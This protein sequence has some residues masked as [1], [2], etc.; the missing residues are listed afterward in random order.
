[1]GSVSSTA[2]IASAASV[3]V[4]SQ[5]AVGRGGRAAGRQPWQP[6]ERETVMRAAR[7]ELAPVTFREAP[8]ELTPGATLP[9]IYNLSLSR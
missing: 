4:M 1:M 7:L 3:V 8:P 5:L 9:P 2:R 6:P